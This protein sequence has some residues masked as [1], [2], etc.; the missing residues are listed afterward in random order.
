M[1][2]VDRQRAGQPAGPPPNDIHAEALRD[3]IPATKPGRRAVQRLN[4]AQPYLVAIGEARELCSEL[5]ELISQQN[6]RK[7]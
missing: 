4:F 1:A 7:I 2:D 5:R 6:R 3:K